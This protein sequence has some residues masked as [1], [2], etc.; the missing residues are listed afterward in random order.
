[1][2]LPL[3]VRAPAGDNAILPDDRVV[4]IVTPA[5]ALTDLHLDAD[6]PS[7]EALPR[8]APS[9]VAWQGRLGAPSEPAR[10]RGNGFSAGALAMALVAGVALG[11]A[12]GYLIGSRSTADIPA[13]AAA[14]DEP[15]AAGPEAPGREFTDAPVAGSAP[16]APASNEQPATDAPAPPET[17]QLLV[18][19]SPAGADVAV[20]GALRG[21]TPLTLRDLTLGTRALVISR[22]GYVPVERSITLTADRPSR[23]LDVQLTPVARRPRP[24]QKS[25]PAPT[26]ASLVVDSRP[27]GASVLLGGRLVGTTPLTLASIAPGRHTIRIE[28]AGYRAFTQTIDVKPGERRRVAASLEGGQQEE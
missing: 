13:V 11:G 12:G 3:A 20:D 14:A 25:P 7:R 27:T 6:P 1:M 17:A 4:E 10:E 19:T 5:V 21:T 16:P 23:S 26:T 18:R 28:R 8:V 9:G 15:T 2:G 22:P 24:T